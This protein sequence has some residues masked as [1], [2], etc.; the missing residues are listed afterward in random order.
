[1]NIKELNQE[2]YSSIERHSLNGWHNTIEGISF[3]EA[4][5][6]GELSGPDWISEG[7]LV[8]LKKGVIH[9]NSGPAIIRPDHGQ[10]IFCLDGL[11]H[12]EEAPAMIAYKEIIFN[13]KETIEQLLKKFHKKEIELNRY[14]IRGTELTQNDFKNRLNRKAIS[15]KLKSL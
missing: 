14:F 9:N 15:K 7:Q 11:Y 13:P 8:H 6:F 12:R 3:E 1:M 2:L 4:D 5:I 10:I